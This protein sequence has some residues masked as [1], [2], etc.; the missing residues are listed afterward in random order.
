MVKPDVNRDYYEDLDLTA[1]ANE[2]DIKEQYRKLG[3]ATACTQ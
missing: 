3:K 2:E 1:S